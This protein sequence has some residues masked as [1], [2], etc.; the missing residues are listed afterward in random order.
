MKLSG[1]GASEG[2]SVARVWHLKEE[3]MAVAHLEGQNAASEA[4]R[5]EA[6]KHK[7]IE[8]LTVLFEKAGESDP[9][10]AAIFDIHRMM[11]E[12][13]DFCE[14]TAAGIDAGHNAEW[15]VEETAKMLHDM[16]ESMDDTYMRARAA[17]VIDISGRVIRILSGASENTAMPSEPVIVAAEDLLPSQT[18]KLD[19]NHVVGYVT[20]KGSLTSH[21]AILARS[22][23]IPCVVGMGDDFDAIPET[24][25]M[26]VDGGAGAV[27][28]SP[29]GEEIAAYERKKAEYVNPVPIVSVPDHQRRFSMNRNIT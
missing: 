27:I 11:L 18:V 5:F 29:T 24:G 28:V 14:G 7:A 15:A 3:R 9:E 16:F 22:M 12:D 26:I 10:T 19:K 25:T 6:A 20:K 17:D 2:I 4:A 13:P 8:E 23:G 1:V 21:S